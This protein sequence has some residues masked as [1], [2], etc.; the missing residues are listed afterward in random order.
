MI[1][2]KQNDQ[3]FE[4]ESFWR[5]TYPFMFPEKRFEDAAERIG[6]ILALASPRGKHVLDLCCGPGRFSVAL[7]KRGFAVTGVDRTKYLLDKARTRAK[8]EKVRVEWI[9][10]DM[11]DFVRPD[12]FDLVLSTYTSFGYFSD[13]NDDAVVLANI[14]TSL[15]P[16]GSF[17][18]EMMGKEIIARTFQPSSADSL[19]DGS[20]LAERRQI[21]DD[22]SRVQNDWIVIK[23]G[24]ARKFTL[25]LNLYSAQELRERMEAAGFVDVKIYGSLKG[26][27]YGPAAHRL[28]AVAKKPAY[29]SNQRRR[30]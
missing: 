27:P 25:L 18:I 10:R 6:Q 7:A 15:R 21:V 12:A 30:S 19:P 29:G 11:R 23:N 5:E 3:W 13:R 4:N 16:C 8:A 22:W 28:I 1:K 14:F 2:R 17:F 20:I 26:D 9:R 24:R